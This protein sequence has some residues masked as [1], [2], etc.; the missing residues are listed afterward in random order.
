GLRGD[1]NGALRFGR[2]HTT[3]LK[4]SELVSCF[5]VTQRIGESG[6]IHRVTNSPILQFARFSPS[7]SS[8]DSHMRLSRLAAAIERSEQQEFRSEA[9]PDAELRLARLAVSAAQRRQD[10]K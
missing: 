2:G 7:E 1:W 10:E 3:V 8:P 4:E 6:A 5:V 9:K